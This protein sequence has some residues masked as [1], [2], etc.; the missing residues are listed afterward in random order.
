MT[1]TVVDCSY[2]PTVW[3]IR[4]QPSIKIEA[5]AFTIKSREWILHISWLNG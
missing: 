4:T 1:T 5:S 3:I 2:L